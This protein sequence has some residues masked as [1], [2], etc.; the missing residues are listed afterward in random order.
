M[1]GRVLLG[2]LLGKGHYGGAETFF[3]DAINGGVYGGEAAEFSHKGIR[4]LLQGIP[5]VGHIAH[6]NGGIAFLG[7]GDRD[8]CGIL[9]EIVVTAIPEA[10]SGGLFGLE[11]SAVFAAFLFLHLGALY[12]EGKALADAANH[13]VQKLRILVYIVVDEVVKV[14]RGLVI[15]TVQVLVVSNL[16]HGIDAGNFTAPDAGHGNAD[17]GKYA[18]YP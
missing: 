16:L 3:V 5:E 13:I 18:D 1:L 4:Q 15:H 7:V 9:V 6:R 17:D 14:V 10:V 2:S 12:L 8:H 11:G